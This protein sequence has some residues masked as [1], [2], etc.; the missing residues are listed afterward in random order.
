M[1]YDIEELRNET[2][3]HAEDPDA[4][5]PCPDCHDRPGLDIAED[6]PVVAAILSHC[7]L[8]DG[9]RSVSKARA[10]AVLPHI[11]AHV[12]ELRERAEQARQL[13][14]RH[15]QHAR[16]CEKHPDRMA[17][18]RVPQYDG[19]GQPKPPRCG[20][21]LDEVAREGR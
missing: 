21:G 9:E 17:N 5:I 6:Q 19:D 4:R 16:D 11:A 13:V 3:R 18:R 2:Y 12:R 1:P 7:P 20:C 14:R 15:G 10:L 8:C